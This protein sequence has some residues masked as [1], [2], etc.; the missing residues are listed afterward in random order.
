MVEFLIPINE[1]KINSIAFHMQFP[2]K[3]S[4]YT[5]SNTI[6]LL[7]LGND[8]VRSLGLSS[9]FQPQ[10]AYHSSAILASAL[11]TLTLPWRSYNG[12]APISS[13]ITELNRYG[14]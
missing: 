12:S 7:L 1:V 5:E 13:L 4:Q 11:D 8:H 2:L 3:T 14:R 10:L 6:F 9:E